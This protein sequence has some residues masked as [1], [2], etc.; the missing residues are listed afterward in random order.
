MLDVFFGPEENRLHGVL[1]EAEAPGAPAVA[2]CHPHPQFGG[3][4]NNNVVLGLEA[5]FSDA[6]ITTLRFNFRGVGRSSGRFDNGVGEK[7]DVLG[8]LSFLASQTSAGSIHLAG[9]SFGA[10][11]GMAAAMRDEKVRS[12]VGVAPPTALG[13]FSFL[14]GCSKPTLAVVGS[15]DEFCDV[16]ELKEDI[17]KCS[18]ALK[19]VPGADHFFMNIEDK[20][21]IIARDFILQNS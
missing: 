14:S 1:L 4:M 9:Y 6:G 18:G 2:I 8:A 15:S 16:E 11:V 10:L 3:S 21:A 13:S 17:E 5:A 19:I 12:I 20:V 7:D